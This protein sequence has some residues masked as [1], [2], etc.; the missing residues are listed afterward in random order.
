MKKV[1]FKL[2]YPNKFLAIPL[3]LFSAILLIYVFAAHLEGSF[4]SYVSY[5]LSTYSLVLFIIW[6]CKACR[7]SNRFIKETK[8]YK[9]YKNHA[10]FV[11]KTTLILSSIIHLFYGVFKLITGLYY[12]S[13][14]FITFAVYYL[15]LCFMKMSLIKDTKYFGENRNKEYRKLKN[16]GIVLFLLN[17]VLSGMIIL[18]I[19]KDNIFP[20]QDT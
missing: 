4:I 6:F 17:I 8:L 10:H 9:S 13:F 20:I 2:F 14:W 12:Q 5:L 1:L 18:I 11:L 3:C 15:I 7:F 19:R 16:T